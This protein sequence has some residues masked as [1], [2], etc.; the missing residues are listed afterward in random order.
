MAGWGG[1]GGTE[2]F[3]ILQVLPGCQQQTE[4]GFPTVPDF[5]VCA[6]GEVPAWPP[7]AGW[8]SR[9]GEVEGAAWAQLEPL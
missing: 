3:S 8:L 1:H 2:I 9:G 4:R 7:A 5:P 6:R